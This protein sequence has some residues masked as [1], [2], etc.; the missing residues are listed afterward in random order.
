M[1]SPEILYYLGKL[2]VKKL[3][4]EAEKA[5]LVN[6]ARQ[7]HSSHDGNSS[8][9][10]KWNQLRFSKKSHKETYSLDQQSNTRICCHDAKL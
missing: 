4:Q 2:R 1:Y 9:I 8:R 6:S 7:D 3:I 5:R 10:I